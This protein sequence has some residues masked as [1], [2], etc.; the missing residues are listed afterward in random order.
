MHFAHWSLC[1]EL[2][3]GFATPPLCAAIPCV[4]TL[5]DVTIRGLGTGVSH[6]GR[7]GNGVTRSVQVAAAVMHNS[8]QP[9]VMLL[10][11][12]MLGLVCFSSALYFAERGDYHEDTRTYVRDDGTPRYTHGFSHSSC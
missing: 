5:Q 1:A 6:R 7:R 4:P 10:F 3:F 2:E 8:W 12:M 9:L 11:V